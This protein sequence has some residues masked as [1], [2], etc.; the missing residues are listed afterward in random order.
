MLQLDPETGALVLPIWMSAGAVAVL[1]VLAALAIARAGAAR[2]V[3]TVAVV[4]ALGYAGWLA[5]IVTERTGGNGGGGDR[6]EER[7]AFGARVNELTGRAML[8]GSPLSCID[9]TAGDQVAIGCEKLIFSGPDTIAVAVSYVAARLAMMSE[10]TELA[11]ASGLSYD[12]S[13]D[14]LRRGLESDRFGIVAY[15]LLQRPTC[16]PEHCDDLALLSDPSK[17]RVNLL[18]KPFDVLVMRYSANWQL[19]G[20]GGTDAR[21]GGPVASAVPLPAPAVSG[22]GAPL[23]SKYDFP[24]ANSIPPVSI[25]NSEPAAPP[26][27]AEKSAATAKAEKTAPAPKAEKPAPAAATRRAAAPKP[28]P[29]AAGPTPLAPAATQGETEQ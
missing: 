20:R 4:G 29:R 6:T 22:T 28:A 7:R 19:G 17:V 2:A 16:K 27:A 9:G 13:L 10:A 25:M 26:A 8:P 23:A 3:M 14:T 12:N 5:W 1:I 15:L 21:G 24:S 11:A 18:E